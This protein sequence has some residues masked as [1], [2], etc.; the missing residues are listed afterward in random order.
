[1]NSSFL[2][3]NFRAWRSN[4]KSILL[5][6]R[7][8]LSDNSAVEN[9]PDTKD[10][11]LLPTDEGRLDHLYKYLWI[12]CV[13][14]EHSVL[15]SYEKFVTLAAKHLNVNHVRTEEPHRYIRRRTLLA[16]RHVHKKYRVQYEIRNYYR[17]LL[18]ENLTG[19]TAD[20][21]LEYIERNIP[22]GVLLVVEKHR[23]GE[24]PFELD[25]N[26]SST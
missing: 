11:S 3:Q 5:A 10:N 8:Q 18:F 25:A 13:G 24:L 20:T 23:L 14:H 15:N 22:E 9:P 26:Q 12:K 6:S 16:S 1:M 2:C 4:S 7:R 21:F 19:S 17:H